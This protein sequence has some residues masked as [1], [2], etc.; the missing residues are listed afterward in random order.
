MQKT[1]KKD[2]SRIV[3]NDLLIEFGSAGGLVGAVEEGGPN[4]IQPLDVRKTA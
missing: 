4:G 2:T 1:D 3:K